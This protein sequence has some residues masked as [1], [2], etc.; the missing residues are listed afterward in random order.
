MPGSSNVEHCGSSITVNRG[1]KRRRPFSLQNNANLT[2]V[3]SWDLIYAVDR[4]CAHHGI[5]GGSSL[6]CHPRIHLR[7]LPPFLRMAHKYCHATVCFSYQS[8]PVH[9][10][11]LSQVRNSLILRK[12]HLG[13]KMTYFRP[14]QDYTLATIYLLTGAP[15][16]SPRVT[17]ADKASFA[18]LLGSRGV[19]AKHPRQDEAPLA[20]VWQQKPFFSGTTLSIEQWIVGSNASKRPPRY[21][22]YHRIQGRDFRRRSRI[23]D[24]LDS[25]L[26]IDSFI[27]QIEF[28][29][30]WRGHFTYIR[31]LCNLSNSGWCKSH[32]LIHVRNLLVISAPAKWYDLSFSLLLI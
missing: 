13:A 4:L 30:Q 17:A 25:F 28:W 10:L 6:L 19:L 11:V 12:K 29:L 15:A 1:Q 27:L 22:D 5:E 26:W 2:S 14:W 20:A 21:I 23:Y 3:P 16:R 9:R 32:S 7:W 8:N 24:V 31:S 18:L